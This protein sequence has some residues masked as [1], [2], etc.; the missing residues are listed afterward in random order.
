MKIIITNETCKCLRIFTKSIMFML[1]VLGFSLAGQATC[2]AT[3]AVLSWDPNTE[4]NLAGYK[5]YYKADSSTPPFDGT[6]AVEGASPIDVHNQTTTTV[7]GLDPSRTYYFVVTAYNTAGLESI[8]SSIV[9]I[10]ESAPPTVAVSAPANN[11]NVSG[12]VSVTASASDN[13]GVTK[14]EFYVNGVLKATDTTTPY[15]YSWNTSSLVSGTYS[16]MTKAYDAAGNVGQSANVSVAVVNDTTAPIVSLTSPVNN[17]TVSGTVTISANA[18]DNVGVSKVEFYQNGALLAA[19]NVIPYSFNWNTSTVTN[20]S[21]T[22]TAKAYDASNNIGQSASLLVTVANIPLDTTAPTVTAFSLP[23]TVTGFTSP[24]SLLSATDNVGVTAYC[25]TTNNSSAGCIWNS[26]VPSSVTFGSTGNQTAW[27]WAKDAAGNVSASKS[28]AVAITLPDTTAPVVS[29]FTMP[30]TATSLSVPVSSLTATDATGVTGYLITESAIAPAATATNWSSTAPTSFTFSAA[31]SKTAYGWAKDAAGNVS[32]SSSVSIVITLPDTTAPVVS[33]F[34]M[35]T[36][37]TSLSVPVTRFTATDAIGVTGYL[38]TESATAPAATATD[39]SSTAPTSF[40]FSSAGR[41]R[42]YA[43]AK[44]A[45]GNVSA[46][47]YAIVTVTLSDTTAPVISE[48]TM[49]PTAT[50]LTVPVSS[51]IATDAIGVTGYLITESAIA[52]VATATDWSSTAP[53][54][55]TFSA[56]GSNTAYAWVK[57]AAG[58]ISISRS[59]NVNTT[60]ALTVNDALTALQMVIGMVQPTSELI[61]RLDVAP[62]INGT[63]Q[64][65]GKVDV[66]DVIMILQMVTGK[67]VS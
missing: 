42:A 63:S 27:A 15:V 58:N 48:F 26:A 31:G 4:S 2:F 32:V 39:W 65:D 6:G 13:V 8:Y 33:S 1:L 40:T 29:S 53:T 36:T 35:L 47:R 28:A 22:L 34:R 45:A 54:S 43:W 16:L 38:I 52:P 9:T 61:R 25:I 30:S 46:S 21:Y 59:A 44:D 50:S 37:S 20:G 49:P 56:A 10:L 66:S 57:D 23:A 5:L 19:S 41:N 67:P 14:V 62:F 18:S 3:T 51:L 7:S 12:T 24:V 64:P 11:A 60:E 55:F 17:S